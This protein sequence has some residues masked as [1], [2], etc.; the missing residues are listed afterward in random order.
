MA[1]KIGANINTT[2]KA[3]LIADV[4]LNTSTA[5]TIIV[6]NADRI[7]LVISNPTNRDVWLQFEDESLVFSNSERLLR[8]ER[9]EMP[10]NIYN[11]EIK[12]IADIGTPTVTVLEY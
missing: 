8:G 11:G 5:V 3:T 12:G 1:K 7:G 4:V 6:A 10:E 2:D 9:Y